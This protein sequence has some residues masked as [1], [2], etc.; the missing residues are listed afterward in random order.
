MARPPPSAPATPLE[1]DIL[2][3]PTL[4]QP[5]RTHSREATGD[6]LVMPTSKHDDLLAEEGLYTAVGAGDASPTRPSAS[7]GFTG[8]LRERWRSGKGSEGSSLTSGLASPATLPPGVRL[9]PVGLWQSR[10]DSLLTSYAS[11]NPRS[12]RALLWLRGPSPAWIETQFPP[13]PLPYFGPFLA[14]LEGSCTRFLAPLQRQRQFTTP[15]FLL[16]WLLGLTFLAR[17]SFFISSTNSGSPTWVDSTTSFWTANDGCGLNGT[18]CEP[19]SNSSLIF[20]C[21]SNVLSTELLNQRTIG[22][23]SVIYEPLVIGGFDGLRTYR[24]DSWVCASAIQHGLFGDKRGGCGQLEMVGS[25]TGF[26]GGRQNGVESVGFES[27][28]PSSYRFIEGVDQGGCQDLRDDILGYEV[29]MSVVFSFFLR[30]APKA[31][32]WALFCFGYWHVVLASDPSAMP[33]DIS[34]G[35][36]SF[37][38]ALFVGSCFWRYAWRFVL[39]A[40]EASGYGVERTV[41]YLGG[42]WFGL[43]ENLTLEWL[44]ID[45]LTPHDI[46]QEPGGLI[47]IICLAIFLFFAILNQLRVIRKTGWFFFYL[48]WYVVGGATI[49]VL[50]ALP[51]LE[52]RLHHYVAAI[53]LIPGTAFVTRPSAIFQGFLTGLFLNGIARWGFDSILETPASLVGDGALGTALPVFLTNSSTAVESLAEGVV[54]WMGVSEAGV[55]GEGWDGFALLVDD[56]L[57]QTGAATN[58]SVQGLETGVVHYFRLAYQNAGTSGDFTKAAQL[59]L[60]NSTWIDPAS[61]PS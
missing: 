19:F 27:E 54:R 9:A 60:G 47:A 45:R 37:L 4:A 36:R 29:A 17:R 52:F 20:R 35:F 56:V 23:D 34:T 18:Y 22:A 59:F 40:F 7:L 25:F 31:F 12:G 16:A 21:P 28:F 1:L 13:F 38:P 43:L 5:T 14:R 49:G 61:G 8:R 41:W 30:P 51:G 57:R 11:R 10:F 48:K 32:F 58:F 46:Q 39:P 6:T 55:E 3:L 44:P 53:C 26:V 33:P 2:P 15:V 24:A 42:F 50:A